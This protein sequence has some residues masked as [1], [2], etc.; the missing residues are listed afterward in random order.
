MTMIT[1][2]RLSNFDTANPEYAYQDLICTFDRYDGQPYCDSLCSARQTGS[3]PPGNCFIEDENVWWLPISRRCCRN[4]L[5]RFV[6]GRGRVVQQF[7]LQHSCIANE[8]SLIVDVRWAFSTGGFQCQRSQRTI[9]KSIHISCNGSKK[10]KKKEWDRL[11]V[12][13]AILGRV[14]GR[15]LQFS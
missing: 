8:W 1:T 11:A 14:Y 2:I 6:C 13:Y 10:A 15:S 12:R 3:N 5:V 4:L 7:V 9:T